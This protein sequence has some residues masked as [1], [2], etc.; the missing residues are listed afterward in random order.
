MLAVQKWAENKHFFLALIAPLL[1]ANARNLH[2]GFS[3]IRDRRFF[4]LQFPLPPLPPWFAMY[5]SHR[6]P[7][8]FLK[9]LLSE[10]S[11]FSKETIELGEAVIEDIRTRRSG[12]S[13]TPEHPLTGE[14][15][16]HV[17]NLMQNILSE[18]FR[19]LKNNF[20]NIPLA[21]AVK[22]DALLM[23]SERELECSFFLLVLAPCW[24][25]YRTTPTILYRKARLG[26]FDSLEKLLCLDPLMLHDPVISR[27][28]QAFRFNNKNTDYQTLIEATLKRPK[29][30]ITL[31]KIKVTIA[32]L[33]SVLAITF[34]LPLEEPD[35]RDLFDAVAKDAEG[36]MID[37]DLPESPESF[38]SAFWR[39]RAVWLQMLKPDK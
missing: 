5:R 18:S 25:L 39:D 7:L 3:H 31:A 22:D 10:F 12:K 17:K 16:E 37:T 28:I 1:V 20:E 13:I 19:N 35:I 6:K 27:R 32:G 34:K 38:Y 11:V 14:D 33:I 21:A 2:S 26:D 4:K 29:A 15:I 8:T 23:I 30:K 9:N 24:L 36:K